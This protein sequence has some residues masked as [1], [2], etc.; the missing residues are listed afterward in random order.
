MAAPTPT[1]TPG[2]TCPQCARTVERD[3]LVCPACLSKLPAAA[4]ELATETLFANA[5]AGTTSADEGRFPAGTVLAGRYRVL[6]LLGQ[7]GMGEVYKAFDLILNQTVALKF[8]AKQ[9]FN[10]AALARF[11]NEVRIARQVSHPNVCRVYDIG[12]V[13][14]L[15]FLS[16][17]YLDGEDLGSLLRRI[18]RLPV[19]KAIEFTRKICTG[20]NAA[21][22]RGI[23]HRDLKPGNIMIDGRGQVRITD[24]GLAAIA[25]EV[26]LGDIRSGTPA[27]MSPEQKAGREVTVRSDIYSLGLVIHEMFTGKRRDAS[28]SSPSDIVKDLDPA[29]DRLILRCLS[30]EPNKRPSSAIAVAMALPGADPIAAA[31]AAGETPSPEMIAASQ[32]KEGLSPRAAI[33]CCAGVIAAFAAGLWL[34]ERASFLA[35][36]PLE[37]TPEVLIDRNQEFLAALGHTRAAKVTESGFDCCDARVATNLEH[38]PPERHA[39]ILAS[40]QPPSIRFS[41]IERPGLLP[42]KGAPK[43]EPGTRE[44]VKDPAGRLLHLEILPSTD[45][46]A[47]QAPAWQ[48]LFLT[49]GLDYARFTSEVPSGL[50]V[51]SDQRYRWRGTYADNRKETV[52][53]NAATWQNQLVYFDVAAVLPGVPPGGGETLEVFIGLGMLFGSVLA[54]RNWRSGRYDPRGAKFLAGIALLLAIPGVI[55]LRASPIFLIRV[56]LFTVSVW[57]FFITVEP[58]ARRYWPDS[59]I[60]FSRLSQGSLRN[61]LVA[62]HILIG[63]LVAEV[64]GALVWPRIMDLAGPI[65]TYAAFKNIYDQIDDPLTLISLAPFGAVGGITISLVYLAG[66]VLNRLLIRKMWLADTLTVILLH[67]VTASGFGLGAQKTAL[68]LAAFLLPGFVWILLVRNYGFLTLLTMFMFSVML[69]VIPLKATGWVAKPLI[70]IHLLPTLAALWALWVIL[71]DRRVRSAGLATA[72]GTPLPY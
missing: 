61:S 11:R 41:Y 31:L 28:S 3:W 33:V 46:A 24:F 52:L 7:G 30:E 50:I 36:V 66:I 65:P 58:Y 14:G 8:L 35:R 9:K 68:I 23:V 54:W 48:E 67:T 53:V 18:G 70:A 43:P 6:G 62:S 16:M 12:I 57:F 71:T 22:E 10:D 26:A 55:A 21:H 4:H 40:H 19:D 32:E 20:L 60:S 29:I 15:N 38:Y 42:A 17:E 51:M 37:K 59:L 13:D 2:N 1:P 72:S 5:P 27:Y 69:M 25:E 44:I 56:L 34:S 49:A 64:F 39:E 47:A 45:Q 63:V